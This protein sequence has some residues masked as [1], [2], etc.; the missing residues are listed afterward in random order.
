MSYKRNYSATLSDDS[1]TESGQKREAKSSN[2]NNDNRSKQLRVDYDRKRESGDASSSRSSASFAEKMLVK[3]G[4][5][6]G[7]GLG[8]ANQGIATPIDE[9]NQIGTRGLG[10][11]VKNFE[12]RIESWNYENDPASANE[13]PLWLDNH[14]NIDVPS[15]SV[16]KSWIKIG[17]VL[18]I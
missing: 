6:K 9:S 13:T 14:D 3:M 16:L 11:K 17:T 8:K 7:K 10:F 18:K 2:Y 15:L 1:D 12:R 5:Q 4:Y